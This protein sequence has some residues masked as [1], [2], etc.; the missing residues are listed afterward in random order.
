MKICL[1]LYLSYRFR[2]VEHGCATYFWRKPL[3]IKLRAFENSEILKLKFLK[4]LT[5]FSLF[6]F[7]RIVLFLCVIDSARY[8]DS[9]GISTTKTF[10]N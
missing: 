7:S 1:E 5:S 6:L 8:S 2:C 9:C 4:G 3:S 10:G